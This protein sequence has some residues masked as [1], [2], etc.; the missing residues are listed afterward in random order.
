[1]L[2]RRRG[3]V[4]VDHPKARRLQSRHG[5]IR[6]LSEISLDSLTG[7]VDSV[8]NVAESIF[9]GGASDASRPRA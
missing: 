8:D 3:D 2:Q 1:M 5:E 9:P 6:H 4:F 7:I